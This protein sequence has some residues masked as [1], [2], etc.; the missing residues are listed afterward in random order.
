MVLR[1]TLFSVLLFVIAVGLGGN[2]SSVPCAAPN[3][4]CMNDTCV[5][6]NDYY[7][8]GDVCELSMFSKCT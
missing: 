7:E 2:C 8:N 3:A 1:L 5:C 4:V 6:D